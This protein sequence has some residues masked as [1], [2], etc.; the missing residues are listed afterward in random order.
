MAFLDRIFGQSK[1]T[2]DNKPDTSHDIES[3]ASGPISADYQD[4]KSRVHN[5]LF[6]FIDFSKLGGVN[7]DR[8]ASDIATLARRILAEEKVPFTHE[9]RERIYKANEMAAKVFNFF[10][11]DK[12]EG[13]K[14]LEYL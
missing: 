9:E 7:E 13:K 5:R 2:P 1:S 4:I 11:T 8:I 3:P 6:D 10:L 12:P 14:A